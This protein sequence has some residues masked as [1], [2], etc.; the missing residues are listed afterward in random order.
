MSDTVATVEIS[1]V[2]TGLKQRKEKVKLFLCA[3]QS[4]IVCMCMRTWM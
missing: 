3:T 1:I 4:Y 2:L